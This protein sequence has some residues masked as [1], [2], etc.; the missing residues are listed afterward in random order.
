MSSYQ[1]QQARFFLE[2][3][4]LPWIND[5]HLVTKRVIE[6]VPVDKGDYRPDPISRTAFELAWHIAAAENRF[7]EAVVNAQFNFDGTRPESIRN[8]ADVAKWYAENF[9][10]NVKRLEQLTD[11]QLLK[12]VDFRGIRVWPA[13]LHLLSGM[14]H[15]IHHRGQLSQYLRPTGAKVPSIYGMSYD[16]AQAA[17]KK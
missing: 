10:A 15:T 16:D 6:A 17:A 3:I 11:E 14:S 2:S 8:S 5:E 4:A 9:E 1:P 7:L 13:V 12:V